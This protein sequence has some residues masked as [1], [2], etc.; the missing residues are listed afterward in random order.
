MRFLAEAVWYPT[1]LLPCACL[2]WEAIDDRSANATLADGPNTV[3]LVFH[4]N[5]HGLIDTVSAG[6][7]GRIV[8]NQVIPTAWQARTW[9][10]EYR[11]GI[12]VPLDSE[13]AWLLPDGP[14]PYWRG[15]LTSLKYEFSS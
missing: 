11:D 13:A 3:R 9:N 7:R 14:E 1:A 15:H 2:H 8:G 4:F 6:A 10:Y 5:D 12:R